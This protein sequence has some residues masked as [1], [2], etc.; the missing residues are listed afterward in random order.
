MILVAGHPIGNAGRWSNSCTRRTRGAALAWK[1]GD[2]TR[3]KLWM[4][5]C[6]SSSFFEASYSAGVLRCRNAHA[7][8]F[9]SAYLLKVAGCLQIS[10]VLVFRYG[11]D[12]DVIFLILFGIRHVEDDRT[13]VRL[14][15]G[16]DVLV[17]IFALDRDVVFLADLGILCDC[18]QC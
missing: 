10:G 2:L 1:V 7:G 8:S 3:D 11:R 13:D 12:L 14:A 17:V 18:R 15:V 16:S 4:R 6:V 9:V 5:K